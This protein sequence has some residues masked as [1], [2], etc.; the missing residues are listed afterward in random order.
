MESLPDRLEYDLD[1]NLN[2]LGNASGHHDFLYTD[3]L[4]D[5]NLNVYFPLRFAANQLLFTDTQALAAIDTS[6]GNDIGDGVF[7]LIAENG[8][9][10]ELEVQLITLDENL[11]ATDSLFVPNT[12]DPAP[13]DGNF[14]AIGK[15]R[16]EIEINLPVSRREKLL[17]AKFIAIRARFSTSSYPQVLQ[18]YSD[19]VLN[20]KL[21]G[22]FIYHIH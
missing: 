9:P 20:L 5:A 8:F 1:F 15:Q 3:D 4:F 10:Y 11:H 2:P 7:T 18:I 17:N 12:I 22:D 6:G 16:T 19:Y 21:V 13:M 14:R